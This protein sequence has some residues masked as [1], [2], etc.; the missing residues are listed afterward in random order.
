MKHSHSSSLRVK[1]V[2]AKCLQLFRFQPILYIGESFVSFPHSHPSPPSS[3]LLLPLQFLPLPLFS[4]SLFLSET[5]SSQ[6]WDEVR[7]KLYCCLVL[8]N[9]TKRES[10]QCDCPFRPSRQT[11]QCVG[12]N[13][14]VNYSS[15]ASQLHFWAEI[16]ITAHSFRSLLDQHQLATHQLVMFNFENWKLIDCK[17]SIF[18]H[19]HLSGMLQ[20]NHHLFSLTSLSTFDW[21]TFWL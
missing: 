10:V 12:V 4:P 11:A 21:S 7:E 14:I 13:E 8:C 17:L 2:T 16:Q 15:A 3:P 9:V 20:A 1:F 18:H 6:P 19:H 5:V